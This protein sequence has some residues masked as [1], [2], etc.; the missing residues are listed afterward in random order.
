MFVH[1]LNF[2]LSDSGGWSSIVFRG[3]FRTVKVILY[4][5]QHV[6]PPKLYKRSLYVHKE[7][8]ESYKTAEC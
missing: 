5:A 2:A 1:V 6:F 3:K 7:Y 8:N 4:K